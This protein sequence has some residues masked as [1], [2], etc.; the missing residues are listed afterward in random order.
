MNHD[1]RHVAITALRH[2]EAHVH[3]IDGDVTTWTQSDLHLRHLGL[4]PTDEKAALRLQNERRIRSPNVLQRLRDR[5]AW[6]AD[7]G[8]CNAERD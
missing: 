2:H 8:A 3:L 5:V 1:H 7:D 4:F 6:R